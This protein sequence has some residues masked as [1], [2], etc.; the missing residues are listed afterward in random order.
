M[1]S[2]FVKVCLLACSWCLP[3]PP[4]VIP[5]RT[6]HLLQVSPSL[7]CLLVGSRGMMYNAAKCFFLIAGFC[8]ILQ[9]EAFVNSPTYGARLTAGTSSLGR[10]IELAHIHRSHLPPDVFY[11]RTFMRVWAESGEELGDGVKFVHHT[12]GTLERIILRPRGTRTLLPLNLNGRRS[13]LPSKSLDYSPTSDLYFSL[14]LWFCFFLLAAFCGLYVLVSLEEFWLFLVTIANIWH[15]SLCAANSVTLGFLKW[16]LPV[17]RLMAT[18]TLATSHSFLVT[19]AE[20]MTQVISIFQTLRLDW[21]LRQWESRNRQSILRKQLRKPGTYKRPPP[22]HSTTPLF[23]R[24]VNH[25]IYALLLPEELPQE[26]VYEP[27]PTTPMRHMYDP[28]AFNHVRKIGSGSFGSIIQVEHRITG[29]MMA[30][31]RLIMEENSCDDVHLE[32][33]ALLRMQR[34]HWYPKV[35]STFMDGANFY[36]LMVCDGCLSIVRLSDMCLA[37]L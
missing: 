25:D 36:I 17:L 33:R 10:G 8:F 20:F 29:K 30:L 7:F 19:A 12:N 3:D 34:S 5:S 28:W 18:W 35:L 2:S 21:E 31:K 26:Q 14:G 9:T 37:I 22:Q 6:R 27:T 15:G 24:G 4:N 16:A 13:L 1:F 32:V 11:N 23:Q